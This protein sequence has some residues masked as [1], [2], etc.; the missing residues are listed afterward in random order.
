MRVAVVCCL[1]AASVFISCVGNDL[2][3]GNFKYFSEKFAHLQILRYKVAGFEKL[4]LQ[5]KNCC[6]ICTQP[7]FPAQT[8]V[9]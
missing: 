9:S 3:I 6:T 5:Q 8:F 7:S 2:N 4:T 1:L